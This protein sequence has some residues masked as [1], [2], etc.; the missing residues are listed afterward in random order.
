ME[1]FYW[2]HEKMISP[3]ETTSVDRKKY[4]ISMRLKT[5]SA[6][7]TAWSA[8]FDDLC[9]IL[10][11]RPLWLGCRHIW[12]V[13]FLFLQYHRHCVL[14]NQPSFPSTFYTTH[15]VFVS[16]TL[17]P[18]QSRIGSGD[19]GFILYFHC[20]IIVSTYISLIVLKERSGSLSPSWSQP[21]L[22]WW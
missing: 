12:Y 13:T 8:K 20:D 21:T 5:F 11:P 3:R 4:Y 16:F 1:V 22:A 9:I 6:L 10:S 7:L 15:S 2:W 14:K 19:L 18:I 17:Y